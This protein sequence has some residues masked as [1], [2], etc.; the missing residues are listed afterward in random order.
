LRGAGTHP[1]LTGVDLTGLSFGL[2]DGGV[3]SF[4][5]SSNIQD[6]AIV[7]FDPK[8]NVSWQWSA[9]AHFDPVM[10]STFP[11]FSVTGVSAPDGG[12]VVDPYH[13]NSI[14]VEPETGDLLVSARDMDS[15]FYVEKAS[16]RVVWKLGGPP[17][18]RD[19][20]TTFVSAGDPFYRQHDARLQPGWSATCSGG[21]GRISLFDDQSYVPGHVARGVVYELAIGGGRTSCG[22]GAAPS[23]GTATVAWEYRGTVSSMDLGSFRVLPDGSHVIG[24]G[25]GAPGLVFS[26]VDVQGTDLLDLTFEGD[27]SYRAVKVPLDALDLDAMRKTAGLPP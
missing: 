20:G 11:W 18:S 19:R 16:G 10:T 15:I 26:E 13:C 23:G 8:G 5:A 2:A 9:Y 17:S 3:A 22:D 4:G 24:W 21:R 7:E 25:N 1:I 14:D 27:T 12:V 6:C